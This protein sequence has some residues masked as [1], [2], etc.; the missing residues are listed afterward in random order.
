VLAGGLAPVVGLGVGLRNGTL[1]ANPIAEA[2]N[3]LGLLALVF[4]I[5]SLTC[6]PLK[7]LS[8]WTWPIRLRKTLGLLSFTYAALHL[9]T[10][11]VVDQALAWKSIAEDL[12]KRPFIM[13]GFATFVILTPLAVTSTSGMLKRLGAARWKK[14]HRLAYLAAVLAITH[15]VLR[16]KK[17]LTEPALYGA[18]VA[19]LFLIRIGAA[20]R[21]RRAARPF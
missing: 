3:Q 2:L 5:A 19:A 10:Y 1:G 16:V 17:D 6:T 14:L 9:I 13:V 12:A 7:T 21:A 20:V 4:L 15:F 18:V 8:G 11:A